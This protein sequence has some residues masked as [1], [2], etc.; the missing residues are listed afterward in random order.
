MPACGTR[1]GPWR[2]SCQLLWR[3]LRRYPGGPLPPALLPARAGGRR[4]RIRL[5]LPSWSGWSW[6]SPVFSS[7]A[8]LRLKR[9]GPAEAQPQCPGPSVHGQCCV[10]CEAARQC[11]PRATSGD[12]TGSQGGSRAR[13]RM[14]PAPHPRSGSPACPDQVPLRLLRMSTKRR[15]T[16]RRVADA[17]DPCHGL[18]AILLDDQAYF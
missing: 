2:F 6:T 7:R 8:R 15:M 17:G 1:H 12:G 10:P 5:L 11:G 9:G 18:G 16:Q 14:R 3:R 13:I 4:L